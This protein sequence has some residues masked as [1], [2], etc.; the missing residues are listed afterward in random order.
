MC[1]LS[2]FFFFYHWLDEEVGFIGNV[3]SI[4]T[5][6]N[7]AEIYAQHK[8]VCRQKQLM[9]RKAFLDVKLL[10]ECNKYS[11]TCPPAILS[12]GRRMAEQALVISHFL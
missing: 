12:L 11:L 8:S 9:P 1:A 6:V 10:C 5:T 7:V 4:V 3:Y 2:I